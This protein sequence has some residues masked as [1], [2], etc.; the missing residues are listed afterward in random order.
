MTT[1]LYDADC[2]FCTASA[3][4]LERRG[5]TAAFEPLQAADLSRLGVD[6]DRAVRELPAVLPDGTVAYG[7]DAVRATLATGPAW[8]R[9][10]GAFLGLR[11][12][13]RPAHALYRW[14]AAHRHRLP[15]GTGACALD[16]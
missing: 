8:M 5:A 12:L 9:I 11:P 1:A 7:A 10:S 14:V 6:G 15:G 2:G 4:W 3:R 16:G 13:R